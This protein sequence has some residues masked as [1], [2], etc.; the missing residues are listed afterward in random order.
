MGAEEPSIRQNAIAGRDAYIAGR[1]IVVGSGNVQVNVYGRQTTRGPL[2]VGSIP[3]E[4]PAFQPRADLLAR[5][6]SEG[7]G[8]SVVRAVTGLRG[9]G[10]TQLAAEYARER[11]AAGWPVVAWTNAEQMPEVL[12]CLA[13]VAGRLGI[14]ARPTAQ[15]SPGSASG[16]GLRPVASGACSYSITSAPLTRCFPTFRQRAGPRSS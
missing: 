13:E 16:A 11:I 6:R 10:K 15:R 8:I 14:A 5:L 3:Q 1:D 7:P 2:V 4:P 9:V 12:S